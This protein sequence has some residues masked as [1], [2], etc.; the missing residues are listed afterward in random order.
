MDRTADADRQQAD[1]RAALVLLS[2]IIIFITMYPF[3]FVRTWDV[4][5]KD[6]R[7]A[8]RDP[9]DLL[10]A[11][12]LIPSVL[13]IWLARVAFPRRRWLTLGLAIAGLLVVLE[14]VQAGVAYRHARVGDL[15]V[16]WVGLWLGML[17]FPIAKAVMRPIWRF[18]RTII[19]LGL[20]G[21]TLGAAAISIE[22]QLGYQLKDWDESFPFLIG[23]EY[24]GHRQWSGVVHHVGAYATSLDDIQ[25]QILF[26]TPMNSIEGIALRRSLGPGLL[27][28][29]TKGY[30]PLGTIDLP[31]EHKHA[32]RTEA[33]LDLTQGGRAKSAHRPDE[34]T[35]AVM[36]SGGITIE[37]QCTPATSTITG[38]ARVVSNSKGLDMRNITLGQQGT[39]AIVRVRTPRSGPNA[40][41]FETTWPDVFHANQRVHIILTSVGGQI[42]FWVDGQ[43]R[44][45][46]AHFSHPGDW[47]K[48]RTDFGDPIAGLVF[49][50]PI[51][52]LATR[53]F[54]RPIPGVLVSIALAVG[55]YA[56]AATTAHLMH[57]RPPVAL[58]WI[59][60]GGIAVGLGVGL[61]I[62]RYGR[63]AAD[64]SPTTP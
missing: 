12:H 54:R 42:W 10:L 45:F 38:P 41:K 19:A 40:T 31:L 13:A 29:F 35:R 5:F 63:R 52:L 51:A 4:Y 56:A 34:L 44:G 50:G 9:F 8:V 43:L 25:T 33:G 16:Q 46:R 61:W 15:L 53:L 7:N 28:D 24:H 39:D 55:V 32:V 47:L 62:G 11:L 21:W 22:G 57:R 58:L 48:L 30:D 17:T 60:I 59:A 27:Y 23:D 26:N 20:L 64:S 3:G 37:V 49:F 14:L 18:R 6:L 36:A 2:I 1:A